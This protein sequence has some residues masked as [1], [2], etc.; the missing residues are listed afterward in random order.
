MNLEAQFDSIIVEPIQLE[1]KKG[2]I[3]VPDT[4]K[5]KLLIGKVISVGPGKYTV[6]GNFIKTTIKVGDIVMLPP[7]GP[8][9]LEFEGKEYYGCSEIIIIAKIN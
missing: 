9:K 2:N 6:T 5:E 7:M 4:G 8:I 3:I 1:T